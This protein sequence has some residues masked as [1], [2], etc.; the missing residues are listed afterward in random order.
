MAIAVETTRDIPDLALRSLAADW[1]YARWSK[2]PADGN[3]Y[4]VIRG[5]LYMTTA[6]SFF[7]H[8]ITQQLVWYVGFPAYRSG[9]MI[10]AFAPVGLL[11]PECDPVQP[12]FVLIR[13][14]RV[15]IIHDRRINGVLDLIVEILSPSNAS[16]D[17]DTKLSAYADAGLPEYVIVNPRARTLS[18]YRLEAPGSYAAPVVY[19]EQAS[20][21][22]D[23]LPTITLDVAVLFAGSPD[24][25]L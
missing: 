14:D 25:T 23:C 6:P 8:W 17:T 19:D 18:H 1:N 3:R 4:E 22:F 5:V 13:A 15:S 16:L 11:M 12:D 24:T 10:F 20:V 9:Q 2:L 21:T 7:H